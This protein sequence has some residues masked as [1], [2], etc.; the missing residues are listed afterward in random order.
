MPSHGSA[1]LLPFLE[2]QSILQVGESA[3][4]RTYTKVATQ[5]NLHL[6]QLFLHLGP[7][8]M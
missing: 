3:S 7:Q 2:K 5:F 1:S 8:A 6:P 4:S